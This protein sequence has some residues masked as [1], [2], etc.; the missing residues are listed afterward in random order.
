MGSITVYAPPEVC[1][2]LSL[3]QRHLAAARRKI[4]RSGYKNRRRSQ[5]HMS[6]VQKLVLRAVRLLGGKPVQSIPED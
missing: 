1:G 6:K 4:Y 5:K 2:A 3:A